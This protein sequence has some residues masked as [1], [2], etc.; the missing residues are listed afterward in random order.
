MLR[1]RLLAGMKDKEPSGE[2]QIHDDITL[3]QIKQQLVDIHDSNSDSYYVNQVDDSTCSS[4]AANQ[5][6]VE[7]SV[8]GNQLRLQ[9]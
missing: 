9:S 8:N 5:W 1:I 7:V 4:I 2:L 6:F 3:E